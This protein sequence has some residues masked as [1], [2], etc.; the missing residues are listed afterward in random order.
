MVA[1]NEASKADENVV[2]GEV[3]K[4]KLSGKE[5]I[6]YYFDF[7]ESSVQFA[8]VGGSAEGRASS[9]DFLREFEHVGPVSSRA[10]KQV[11][12]D[13]RLKEIESAKK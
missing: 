8:P 12:N 7:A 3:Y 10:E 9:V 6:P 1:K 5:V 11:S 4:N 13:A 2:I